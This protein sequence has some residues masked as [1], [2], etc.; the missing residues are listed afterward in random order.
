MYKSYNNN[1]QA[2]IRK[3]SFVKNSIIINDTEIKSKK[4]L[5]VSY[6]KGVIILQRHKNKQ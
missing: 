6:K 2:Y 3:Y 4:S 5:I 1:K